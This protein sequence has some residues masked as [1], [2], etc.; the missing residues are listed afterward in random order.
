MPYMMH[1][2]RSLGTV[3]KSPIL[4]FWCTVKTQQTHNHHHLSRC[5]DLSSS[6]RST[7]ES[8]IHVFGEPIDGCLVAACAEGDEDLLTR[9]IGLVLLHD[10]ADQMKDV[11]TTASETLLHLAT[12]TS[13]MDKSNAV[14]VT[15]LLNATNARWDVSAV[16]ST[17]MTALHRA[18]AAGDTLVSRLLICN[19]ADPNTRQ[20][21][22]GWT[23][24]DF[25]L[26]SGNSKLVQ[27][28]LY[29]PGIS[30]HHRDRTA[31][32]WTPIYLAAHRLDFRSTALLFNRGSSVEVLRSLQ[33]F[34]QDSGC[35]V[36]TTDIIEAVELS[37]A[38]GDDHQRMA[39]VLLQNGCAIKHSS[40]AVPTF[41]ITQNNDHTPP[42]VAAGEQ[43]TTTN[44]ERRRGRPIRMVMKDTRRCMDCLK[45]PVVTKPCRSCSLSFCVHCWTFC[46]TKDVPLLFLDELAQQHGQH[47]EHLQLT[48][49]SY[50]PNVQEHLS[51]A[52][53]LCVQ[54]GHHHHDSEQNNTNK[55]YV[56]RRR[57][58]ETTTTVRGREEQVICYVKG[59][60]SSDWSFMFTGWWR[61]ERG[62]DQERCVVRLCK[63]CFSF[64]SDIVPT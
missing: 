19:G 43:P 28:L 45:T 47:S 33:P 39:A 1:H 30:I 31:R 37:G 34:E 12:N 13:T 56:R 53:S 10:F 60:A 35:A 27:L 14:I 15:Q 61:Q 20:V 44:V 55:P 2:H 5:S 21:C 29:Y 49:S 40:L 41:A 63:E 16:D 58:H 51:E 8:G 26:C 23:A 9:A 17:G 57:Q 52:I 7:P 24:L 50:T 36:C 42:G 6:Y 4:L 46:S 59:M 25:A 18:C 32:G 62:G 38:V 11:R 54:G 22:C 64:Y 48:E 3:I